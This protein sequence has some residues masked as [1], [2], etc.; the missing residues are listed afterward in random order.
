LPTQ[1]FS[2]EQASTV[3]RS[4][5]PVSLAIQQVASMLRTKHQ[6]RASILISEILSPPLCKRRQR[7]R[8]YLR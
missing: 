7:G 1:A 8:H 4:D 5:V 2:S 3:S 6:V